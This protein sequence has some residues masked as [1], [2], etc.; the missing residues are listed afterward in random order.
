[1]DEFGQK[2]LKLSNGEAWRWPKLVGDIFELGLRSGVMAD[3]DQ[4][5]D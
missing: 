2:A 1:M 5:I 3:D 4:R